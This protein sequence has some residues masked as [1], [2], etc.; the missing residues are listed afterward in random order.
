MSVRST[1]PWSTSHPLDDVIIADPVMRRMYDLVQRLAPAKLPV[2]IT[3]ETGTG[4]ERIATALHAL[5]PRAPHR[6]LALNCAALSEKL[7]ESELFGHV[8]GAFS[9]AEVARAGIIETSSGSTLFLD[10]VGELPLLIQAKLLRVLEAGHVT[11]VGEVHERA[12]NVRIVA[13]T[14]RNLEADVHAGL[15]RRDLYYRL[16]AAVV[17]LPPL[18]QRPAELPLLA[19]RFLAD[20][21]RSSDRSPMS[22]QP[23][24][25]D[26]LQTHPWPGNVR[27]LKNVMSFLA[28]TLTA[29]V[30]NAEDVRAQLR[31]RAPCAQLRTLDDVTFVDPPPASRGFRPLADELR[32]IEQTRIQEALSATGGQKTRA[33][34]L[35]GMPL[36]T[37]YERIKQYGLFGSSS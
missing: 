29:D 6:L 25:I 37:L 2:L 28:A 26:V 1:V 34:A 31:R 3:G 16:S 7:V 4:K 9:G 17:H 14:N 8:R 35:L 36:R 13:A 15:F 5:S 10:E 21:A 23:E 33:A 18:R 19:A 12:V 32:E 30:V 20:A 27:E 22:L 24:A 11:R